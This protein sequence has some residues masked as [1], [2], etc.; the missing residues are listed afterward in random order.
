MYSVEWRPKNSQS[1][2]AWNQWHLPTLSGWPGGHG[3]ILYMPYITWTATVLTFA[4]GSSN[5]F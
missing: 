1:F 4:S 2:E 5:A 3:G